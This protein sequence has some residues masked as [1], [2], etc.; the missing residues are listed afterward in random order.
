MQ[1]FSSGIR[2]PMYALTHR[3]MVIPYIMKKIASGKQ[4]T[5]FSTILTPAFIDVINLKVGEK[6]AEINAICIAVYL[7]KKQKMNTSRTMTSIANTKPGA[8]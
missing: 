3:D 8:T 5:A 7:S 1:K 2:L 4:L 6:T